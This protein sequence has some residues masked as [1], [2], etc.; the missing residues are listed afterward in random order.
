MKQRMP[1]KPLIFLTIL[2]LTVSVL[3]A[4]SCRNTEAPTSPVVTGEPSSSPTEA[5]TT[6]APVTEAPTT[7]SETS[8]E[9]EATEPSVS[10]TEPPT[11]TAE[12]IVYPQKDP[13]DVEIISVSAEELPDEKQALLQRYLCDL[14]VVQDP[15]GLEYVSDEVRE[16]WDYLPYGGL[17][18]TYSIVWDEENEFIISCYRRSGKTAGDGLRY[19]LIIFRKDGE[20]WTVVRD[21]HSDFWMM[22]DVSDETTEIVTEVF[23]KARETRPVTQEEIREARQAVLERVVELQASPGVWPEEWIENYRFSQ[24]VVYYE[25]WSNENLPLVMSWTYDYRNP[26]LLFI[27]YNHY[28]IEQTTILYASYENGEWVAR[29]LGSRY[30]PELPF[31]GSD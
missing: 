10:E 4:A 31:S 22:S 21:V 25:E 19:D 2:L 30:T 8:S 24:D 17:K 6:E 26:V 15:S 9:P 5:P 1:R 12:P 16:T 7:P 23:R 27:D 14:A 29:F 11:E 20:Q 28:G 3:L 13:S 18:F